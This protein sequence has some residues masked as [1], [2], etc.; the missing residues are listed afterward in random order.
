MVQ[1]VA[2]KHLVYVENVRVSNDNR[3]KG[4]RYLINH[5][6]RDLARSDGCMSMRLCS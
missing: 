5:V 1:S 6:M 4:R 2:L 3:Q